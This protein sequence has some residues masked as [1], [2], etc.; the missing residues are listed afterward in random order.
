MNLEAGLERNDLALAKRAAHTLVGA[1]ANMGATRLEAVAAAMEQA[2]VSGD[3]L[4]LR[5]LLPAARLRLEAALGELRSLL[6]RNSG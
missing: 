1:S 4:A 5:Q 3:M 6:S 2:A